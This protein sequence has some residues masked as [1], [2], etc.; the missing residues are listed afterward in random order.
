MCNVFGVAVYYLLEAPNTAG[1]DRLTNKI[2]IAMRT[3]FKCKKYEV[4]STDG[5]RYETS[6]SRLCTGKNTHLPVFDKKEDLYVQV[7]TEV[8]TFTPK[9]IVYAFR[10]YDEDGQLSEPWTAIFC[11][12]EGEEHDCVILG[13]FAQSPADDYLDSLSPFDDVAC[14]FYRCWREAP[15]IFFYDRERNRPYRPD[16]SKVT[17]PNNASCKDA[18]GNYII[19]GFRYNPDTEEIEI[20]PLVFKE[21]Y[22]DVADGQIRRRIPDVEEGKVF[23]TSEACKRWC[24]DHFIVV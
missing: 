12:L 9:R 1:Q 5:L 6:F 7:G 2:E 4:L 3:L 24:K 22:M 23:L 18:D 21:V 20:V 13:R 8:K 11:S 10:Y 17:V 16:L 19:G 15:D 14:G